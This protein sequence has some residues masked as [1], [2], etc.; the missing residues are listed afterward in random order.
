MPT[1]AQTT[2]S[3]LKLEPAIY[4]DLARFTAVTFQ[5]SKNIPRGTILA[6]VGGV[7][8]TSTIT[9]TASTSGG[10]F[11]LTTNSI[12]TGAITWSATN[13]TLLANIQTAIDTAFGAP[14]GG[15]NFVPTAVALTAGI[16]TILLTAGNAY[17]AKP[18]A[19]TLQDSTTGGTGTTIAST[20][21]GT[22]SA[23]VFGPYL[24]TNTDGTQTPKAIAMYDMQTDASS[25]VTF[26]STSS[27]AGGEFGQTY[28]TAPVWIS[29]YFQT[30]DLVGLDSNAVTVLK[31]RFVSGNVS[32]G[33]LCLP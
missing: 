15:H 27:Q 33:I 17:G 2:F 26:S 16:G 4:P 12:V 1:S 19:W 14:G 22:V 25:N 13:A 5:A 7:N 11:T 10:T 21:T 20:T 24:S 8:A 3:N 30:T 18:V 31:A 32:N 6:E 23:G 28:L 9:I 29:G